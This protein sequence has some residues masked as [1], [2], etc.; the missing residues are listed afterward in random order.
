M[1]I[2]SSATLVA[3]SPMRSR[4]REIENQVERRFDRCR[5]LQHVGEQFAEDLCLQPV[6]AVVFVE[7]LLREPGVAA[8][9]RIERVAQHRLRDVAHLRDVDQ[10]LDRRMRDVA[11]LPLRRC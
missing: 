7:H 6:E 11:A 5:I 4:W 9:E 10:L 1:K 3:W 8:D 2:T